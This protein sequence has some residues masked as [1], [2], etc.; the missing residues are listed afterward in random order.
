MNINLCLRRKIPYLVLSQFLVSK[1]HDLMQST[2]DKI[3]IFMSGLCAI[4][5]AMLPILLS[6]S[7]VVPN[8]AHFGHGWI[9]MTAIGLIAL[10]SFSRG[11]KRHHDKRVVSL[12]VLGFGCLIVATLMEDKVD[13]IVESA[14]FVFGGVVMVTAHWRNYKLMRCIKSSQATDH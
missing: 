5:C 1:R 10:W 7:A 9:W 2:A 12:F 6:I 8:W 3:G 13:I 4:Q 11:W 14:M